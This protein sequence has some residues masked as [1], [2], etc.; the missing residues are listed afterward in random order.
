MQIPRRLQIHATVISAVFTNGVVCDSN[1]NLYVADSTR[2]A[3]LVLA[4]SDDGLLRKYDAFGNVQWA[5]RIETV[6]FDDIEDVAKHAADNA[7]VTGRT[8]G[9]LFST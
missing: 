5:L 8:A 9:A 4:G 1:G 6:E 2:S 3:L 7:L